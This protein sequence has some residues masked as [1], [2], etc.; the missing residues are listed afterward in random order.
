MGENANTFLDY[1]LPVLPF[2]DT[3]V[4]ESRGSW[5]VGTNGKSYLDLNSGQF[6]SIFGHSDGEL[7]SL[8][9]EIGGKSQ[10][11]D[12]STISEPVLRA[13]ALFSESAPEMGKAKGILLSTGGEANEFALRYAKHLKEKNGIL[14]LDRGYHGLTLGT[15]GYSMSRDRVRPTL[16]KSFYV[17]CPVTFEREIGPDF[18]KKLTELE[19]TI[20]NHADDIAAFIVEPIVSGGGMLFPPVEYF[21]FA[22]ELCEANDIFLIFD[23]CQTGM[24]RTGVTWNYQN[25]GVTPDM[26]VTSKGFGAGLPIAGVLMRSEFVP[27]D[28][29]RLKHFSSHQ[30]EPLSGFIVEH[31]FQRLS[32]DNILDRVRKMGQSLRA[33]LQELAVSWPDYVHNIR[34]EGLM[35]GFDLVEDAHSPVSTASPLGHRVVKTAEQE[36]LFL[37]VCNFDRTVRVLPNY[38]VSEQELQEFGNRLDRTFSMLRNN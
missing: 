9:S 10:N 24:G 22:K 36:G 26:L 13:M 1:L 31:I 37:Q 12:T 19:D 38:L 16:E 23:E 29:F 6:C 8:L 27:G 4:K 25:L 20:V 32:R 15:A 33:V 28:G 17:E 11:S 34:G 5:V 35:Y 2:R 30:N 21:K 3:V 7:R 18:E 14:S